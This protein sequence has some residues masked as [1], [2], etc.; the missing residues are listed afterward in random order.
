MAHAGTASGASSPAGTGASTTSTHQDSLH[1]GLV[2][3]DLA[4]IPLSIKPP[5]RYGLWLL[6]VAPL[7]RHIVGSPSS[8]HALGRDQ[9][10]PERH[11]DRP[12]RRSYHAPSK[13]KA[14]RYACPSCEAI[15]LKIRVGDKGHKQYGAKCLG[16]LGSPGKSGEL[17]V[18]AEPPAQGCIGRCYLIPCLL[19]AP[20]Q[21]L[22]DGHGLCGGNRRSAVLYASWN[23]A[24]IGSMPACASVFQKDSKAGI[25][26]SRK[27][28]KP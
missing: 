28:E 24:D 12:L 14:L 3:V 27:D 26:V 11:D 19:S 18:F 9:R 23:P 20:G 1:A 15:F 16:K 6:C 22:P 8:N 2:G 7:I 21:L 10:R 5:E 17:G 4:A 25:C 13:G